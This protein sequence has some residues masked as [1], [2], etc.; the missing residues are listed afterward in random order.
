M[1]DKVDVFSFAVV[2]WEIWTLGATPYPGL[3]L[4][5]IFSGGEFRLSVPGVL[6]HEQVQEY[7]D[8]RDRSTSVTVCMVGGCQSLALAARQ[9]CAT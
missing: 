6:Y 4:P 3:T 5:A 7:A 9:T 8:A 1:T 2:M